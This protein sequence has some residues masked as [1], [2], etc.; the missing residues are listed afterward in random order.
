MALERLQWSNP[1]DPG[2][3]SQQD[4][5]CECWGLQ[6]NTCRTEKQSLDESGNKIRNKQMSYFQ[7]LKGKEVKSN[8]RGLFSAWSFHISNKTKW[9]WRCLWTKFWG[10][11]VK[12]RLNVFLELLQIHVGITCIMAG[13][14]RIIQLWEFSVHVLKRLYLNMQFIEGLANLWK[15]KLEK[16]PSELY[17]SPWYLP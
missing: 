11:A 7:F 5:L 16:L 3:D 14:W 13:Y 8:N 1:K 12:R 4:A 9:S 10:E 15:Y 2:A 17:Q 6:N